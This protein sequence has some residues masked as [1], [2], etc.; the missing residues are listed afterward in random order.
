MP[1]VRFVFRGI[2]G[3]DAEERHVRFSVWTEGEASAR[4]EAAVS[5]D[6]DEADRLAMFLLDPMQRTPSRGLLD[7]LRSV[8]DRLPT[9][10]RS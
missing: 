8:R 6:Q 10:G 1:A 4:A 9:S 3:G 5:L 2:L 7:K